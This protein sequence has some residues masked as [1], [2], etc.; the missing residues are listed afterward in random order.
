M[1]NKLPAFK[2]TFSNGDIIKTNMAK[3][4]DL[5]AAKDYYLGNE[6]VAADEVTMRTAISV[7]QITE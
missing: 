1:N 4:I 6:F 2:I 3:G 5:A 7:E